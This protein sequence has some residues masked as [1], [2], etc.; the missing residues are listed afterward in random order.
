MKGLVQ[1][2]LFLAKGDAGGRE[3]PQETVSLSELCESCALSFD[4]VAFERGLTLESRIGPGVS[5]T[6]RGEDLRRLCA[7]LL[8]NACKYC[9]EGGAV[10]VTLSSPGQAV[11]TVHNTGAPIPAEAQPHL[12]ELPGGRGPEPGTGRVRPW[13][14]HRRRH[15]GGAPGENRRPQHSGGGNGVHRHPAA[16]KSV[17]ERQAP[18]LQ[19]AY[20]GFSCVRSERSGPSPGDC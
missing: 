16:D 17:R 5:V 7:I 18:P 20:I 6:G 8:D 2:L 14:V 10:T 11:L 19:L 15:C 1:D 9:G 12:F 4:P 3:R 13:P